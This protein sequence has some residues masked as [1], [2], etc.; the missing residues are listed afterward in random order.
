MGLRT[1]LA[2]LVALS[3]GAQAQAGQNAQ[4]PVSP[5]PSLEGFEGRT[6]S[7]VL[8]A[9][10]PEQDV[11]LA[12]SLIQQQAGKPLSHDA[13]MESVAALQQHEEY[14][15]VQLSIEP[16]SKGVRLV[17]LIQ[18]VYHVG[19]ISFPTAADKLPY[20]QLLQAVDFPSDA[21]FIADEMPEREA[22]LKTFLAQQGYFSSSIQ[23]KTVADRAHQLV[24]I[25]FECALGPRA[26]VGEIRVE[27]VSQEESA[28]I[29][30]ALRSLWATVN[31]TSLRPGQPYSKKHIDKALG[32][33]RTHLAKAGRLAPGLRFEPS[34]DA[35]ARRANITLEV[36][37][38]P[39]VTVRINGAKLW[40][41]TLRKLIPIYQENA[42]DQ[43]LVDE[44][45]RNLLSYFQA[46]SYFD[47]AV[48]A[49]MEKHQDDVTI[50]YDVDLGKKHRVE[51]I[52]FT[53]NKY[54][55]DDELNARVAIHKEKFP[56]YR[57]KY[58]E[59]LLKKSIDSLLA[60]YRREGFASAKLTT[61]VTDDGSKVDVEFLIDE[62]P[63]D[64]VRNLVIVDDDAKQVQ[65]PLGNRKLRL[66]AGNPYSPFYVN[67]DRSQILAAY[68]NRGY[69]EV[70]MTA[71]AQPAVANPHEID[72]TYKIAEGRLVR[73]QEVVLLGAQHARATFVESSV[74]QNVR[75]GQPLGQG[76]LLQSESD[77]YALGIFDWAS[78]TPVESDPNA[79]AQEVL[80]RVHESKRNSLDVGG[81]LEVIPRNGNL[82]VGAVA[83]PGLPPVNLGSKFTVTQK[84]FVG[85]R[86][87]A[88]FAR[89]D[90]LGRAETAAVGLLLSRLDQ[91]A[92][93][94]YGDPDL[95]GSRWS[96]LFSVTG[97]RTTENPIFTAVVG[98]ASFQVETNLDKRK[99]QKIVTRYSYGR[100]DLSNLL[101][102]DLVLPRDRNVRLSTVSADYI[103]DTRDKPLDAHHGQFESLSF[104]VTPT[105]FG[106][107]A[108]FA[109][110]LAQASFYRPIRPWLIWANN[111]RLGLAPPFAGS[112]VPL[113]ERFFSG[114]AST[115]RGFA[116]DGAGPQ[117][118]VKVCNNPADTSTCTLISVPVGGEMV[119]ILNSEARFPIPFKKD[120]GGVFFYDGG[121]VYNSINLH[122]FANNYTNTVG[123]GIRYNTKVGPIRFDIARRLTTIPGVK[124]TQ[125][126]ITLG[127][128]F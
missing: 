110:F 119:A 72:V 108:N 78:V 101:L 49:K 23:T 5:T 69:P 92:T 54:F 29:Q 42:V 124:A 58:S 44:G 35:A 120:L 57:G 10:A 38:G 12:R 85:P 102:P 76:K 94:S 47:A 99:T 53:N 17:F 64:H 111:F 115:L 48:T 113:S 30:H 3:W 95:G 41:R 9:L 96:S 24:N 84:S 106:A 87:T 46:K 109:K 127:Q 2:L 16:D 116:I 27:G 70:S 126:F 79:G 45:R 66:S 1:T 90:I 73:T 122:Q 25:S 55:D 100:T 21:P 63:Q 36:Q 80:V 50:T 4:A 98:Q 43:D 86:V 74:H 60:L 11:Q 6:V 125:Y 20:S 121:N 68:L 107:S 62:G 52:L 7:K 67:E 34:Y 118:P 123:A 81:G 103:R 31:G 59:A 97:E 83:L 114:G 91:K 13:I 104:A 88:Q 28:N 26:K 39:L 61:N 56:F 77:L 19:L 82:P 65:P 105:I 93:F 89:H 40:K 22:A 37:P 117:R 32:H 128:A 15:N 71:A 14:R 18:P 112:I 51:H 75:A 33:V 8:V